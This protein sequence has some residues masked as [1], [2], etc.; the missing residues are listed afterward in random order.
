DPVE[1][2]RRLG[3]A[4]VDF[5]LEHP[6]HYRFLFMTAHPAL[7]PEESAIQK[8]NPDEDAYAFLRATVVEAIA[9][10]RLRP[11]LEDPDFLSQLAWR[12]AAGVV[13]LHNVKCH[14]HWIEWRPPQKLARRL[15][16]LTIEGLL[17]Q[18]R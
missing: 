16:D 14:D 5:A 17:R 9:Q 13:G 3:Y 2:L 12:A 15:I 10:G 6:N 8:G 7:S 11:D 4:Y 18:E 1:R